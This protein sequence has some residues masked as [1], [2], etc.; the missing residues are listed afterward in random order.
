MKTGQGSRVKGERRKKD[1]TREPTE[2][3][4]VPG[5]KEVVKPK[6]AR[7]FGFKMSARTHFYTLFV[8]RYSTDRLFVELTKSKRPSV[9]EI[10]CTVEG[11]EGL[12]S[13]EKLV[14]IIMTAFSV[15]TRA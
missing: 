2:N 12:A 9:W 13:H 14:A 10:D 11:G 4:P 8:G 15:C 6:Y 7:I 3:I 5:E 1:R